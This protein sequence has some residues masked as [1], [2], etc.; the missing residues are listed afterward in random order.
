M[1]DLNIILPS[2][3]SIVSEV[4]T[5]GVYEIDG[6]YP[7][8]GHT[9]GNS[10]RRIILSSLSGS[11]ITT[12]KIEGADHEFSVLDGVKEDVI[13]ILL[14]LK[15]VRFRLLTDE[16]QTVKLS[17]KGPK[18]V[19]A[20][21]IE[22]GG[23]VEVL[24]KDLYIAELTSKANLSIEMTVEKGLGFV[25]KEVHQKE[26][27]DVGTI[28]LDAIF[29]PIRRV[30]YEVEN[31]RVGDKTNHNR[32]R[33]TIETDGTLTPREALEKAI[34]IM[35]EQLQA[36]IGF[37]V[38][39]KSLPIEE[40]EQKSVKESNEEKGEG[41]EFTDILK[42]RIDTLTL[43]TR[44]LNALTDAN[45]RTIGGIARKKKEDLLEIDGIGDKGIQEI[46][47]VLGEYGITLK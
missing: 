34:V 45:I 43:S 12:L 13:T 4:D 18:L 46:K 27:N 19:T 42:T 6:L 8:Y 36:I 9:L 17:V 25:P 14:H 16:P 11:A 41:N 35:V 22:A 33:M 23:Q 21:D 31:M 47:K 32:L 1:S 5:K 38:M 44:T 2:K 20:A 24:N 37:T 29:T 15:Q 10:L 39:N 28:S 40:V 3:L 7:G 26:K 30:A